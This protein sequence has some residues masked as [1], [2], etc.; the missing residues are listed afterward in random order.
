VVNGSQADPPSD[1]SPLAGTPRVDCLFRDRRRWNAHMADV[2]ESTHHCLGGP[3][4]V[5]TIMARRRLRTGRS[6]CTTGSPATDFPF[7]V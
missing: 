6:H 7:V 3:K 5:A 4:I 2:V 1:R